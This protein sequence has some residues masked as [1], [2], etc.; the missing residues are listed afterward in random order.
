MMT[1]S[2]GLGITEDEANWIS[3][4]LRNLSG[5]APVLILKSNTKEIQ[6]LETLAQRI[7]EVYE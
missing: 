1:V 5:S 6:E 2:K 3:I 4:A 7:D